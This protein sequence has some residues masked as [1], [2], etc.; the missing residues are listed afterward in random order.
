MFSYIDGSS[1]YSIAIAGMLLGLSRAYGIDLDQPA[2]L[3]TLGHQV[4]ARI[5]QS[6]M[7]SA[8]GTQTVTMRQ[9]LATG[10][11]LSTEP[12]LES[13]VAAQTMGDAGIPREPLLMAVGKSDATGDGAMVAAD[14]ASLAA[15]YCSEGVP[16]EFQQYAGLAH[17][18]AA[19][20]FEPQTGPFLQARFAGAPPVDDCTLVASLAQ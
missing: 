20:L 13:I 16:V 4:V 10:G 18:E 19:A 15:K 14:V 6:C 3:S 9:L 11:G 1:Q 5:G 12:T 17:E 2:Y 8:F 7:A